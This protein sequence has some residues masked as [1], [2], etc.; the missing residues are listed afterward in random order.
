MPRVISSAAASAPP[1]STVEIAPSQTARR[2]TG[3]PASRRW[4]A[5]PRRTTVSR[6][7]SGAGRSAIDL[8]QL[9][10]EGGLAGEGD[11]EDVG[12]NS[13]RLV[14]DDAQLHRGGLLRGTNGSTQWRRGSASV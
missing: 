9:A 12:G 2:R 10:L 1:S 14:G 7:S 8:A 13:P 3:R 5:A 4:I 6:S 11:D